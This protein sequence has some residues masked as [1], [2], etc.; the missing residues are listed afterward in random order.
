MEFKWKQKGNKVYLDYRGEEIYFI[1]PED[2]KIE[3][4]HSDT[5]NLL[6]CL[7]FSPW[8]NEVFDYIPKGD[9]ISKKV[10]LAFST[11]YDSTACMLL[12]P[13]ETELF[14]LYRDFESRIKHDNALNFINNLKDKEVHIIKSNHE[15]IRGMNG[16]SEGFSNHLACMAHMILLADYYNLKYLCAGTVLESGYLI[17][18]YKFKDYTELDYHLVWKKIFNE[19]GFELILPTIGLSEVITTKIVNESIYNGLAYGC[20]RKLGGCENCFKCYRKSILSGKEMPLNKETE[21]FISKDPP[22]MA[23]S[24][25]WGLNKLNL[26]TGVD[27]F[28][29]FKK[30][31]VSFLERYYSPYLNLF[32]KE[33]SEFIENKLGILGIRPMSSEDISNLKS[34]DLTK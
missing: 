12:L 2:F 22:K 16:L 6:N 33:I 4:V 31:D 19:R 32:P 26:R 27:S 13:K 8:H 34:F 24:L 14:Y 9:R 17:S 11:G 7:L 10:G 21:I 5:F 20:L 25:L 15:K 3:S 1:V 28:D 23:S 30:E 29:K 18:G